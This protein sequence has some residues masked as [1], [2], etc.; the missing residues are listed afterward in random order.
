[1]AV[2]I[3]VK[4]ASVKFELVTATGFIPAE[5]TFNLEYMLIDAALIIS[6]PGS[7]CVV[8]ANY[9]NQAKSCDSRHAHPYC[10]VVSRCS[11]D[12]YVQYKELGD[13]SFP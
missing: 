5:V 12:T 11:R 4:E 9:F 1:M 2:P 10:I 13:L 7:D 3:R 8:Q 6:Q